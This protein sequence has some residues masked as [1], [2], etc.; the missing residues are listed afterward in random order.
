MK[1][2]NILKNPLTTTLWITPLTL[3]PTD[4]LEYK[5]LFLGLS[6]MF[7]QR[8]HER[9]DPLERDRCEASGGHPFGMKV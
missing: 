5:Y 9:E 2:F 1:K 4:F 3:N 6:T 8:Q 7:I